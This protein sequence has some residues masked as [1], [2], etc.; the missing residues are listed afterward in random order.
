MKQRKMVNY[1]YRETEMYNP[2]KIAYGNTTKE[3]KGI[4]IYDNNKEI[5]KYS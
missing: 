3:I 1:I 2:F 5:F 4:V